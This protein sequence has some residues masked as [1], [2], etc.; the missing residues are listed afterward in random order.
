MMLA[1]Y[2]RSLQDDVTNVDIVKQI[3]ESGSMLCQKT[4]GLFM[5]DQIAREIMNVSYTRI[6]IYP[7]ESSLDCETA[8][9]LTTSY[10]CMKSWSLLY[11]ATIQA[12]L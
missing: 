8:E 6:T 5:F 10:Q 1:Q 9:A 4:N 2:C 3:V 7:N 12:S 11:I